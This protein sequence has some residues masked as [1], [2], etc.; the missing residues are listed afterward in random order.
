MILYEHNDCFRGE[1]I[2]LNVTFVKLRWPPFSTFISD[3]IGPG[4]NM[5][6]YLSHK[7]KVFFIKKLT[8]MDGLDV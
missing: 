1:S 5:I 8:Y 6:T 2:E 4:F 3:F 7:H